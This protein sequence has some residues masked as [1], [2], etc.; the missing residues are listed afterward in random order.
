[1][2]ANDRPILKASQ[3]YPVKI[4]ILVVCTS[5]KG[6]L[7]ALYQLQTDYI[8]IMEIYLQCRLAII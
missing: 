6:H 1:M 2:V 8:T 7:V 4:V 3:S 5:Q